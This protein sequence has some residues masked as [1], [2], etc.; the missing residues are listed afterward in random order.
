[1]LLTA[2]AF[3]LLSYSLL[4]FSFEFLSHKDIPNYHSCLHLI[5]IDKNTLILEHL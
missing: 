2:L 5:S 3:L 1:M 4:I